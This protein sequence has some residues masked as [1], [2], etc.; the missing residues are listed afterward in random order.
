[1]ST[2]STP[3]QLMLLI[4]MPNGKD[5]FKRKY[6]VESMEALEQLLQEDE[7]IKYNS[8]QF[9][10]YYDNDF[11]SYINVENLQNVIESRRLKI[12]NSKPVH[13]SEQIEAPLNS[14]NHTMDTTTMNVPDPV[15]SEMDIFERTILERKN[16]DERTLNAIL[17]NQAS[18]ALY[19]QQS[20]AHNKEQLM[21]QLLKQK[22]DFTANMLGTIF[23]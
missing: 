2:S 6:S 4:E 1:M 16:V 8:T 10:Q 17:Q 12:C 5:K 21:Y 7:V 3:I 14:H 15:S 22:T 20:E 11:N 23:K 18:A 13:I 9:I 19:S